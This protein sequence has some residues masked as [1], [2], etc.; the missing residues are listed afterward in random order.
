MYWLGV[1][2][3]ITLR[4]SRLELFTAVEEKGGK[5]SE[6]KVRGQKKEEK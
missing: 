4:L 2:S 5:R 1:L 6:T 3:L